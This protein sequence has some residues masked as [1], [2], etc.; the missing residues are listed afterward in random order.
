MAVVG[1]GLLSEMVVGRHQAVAGHNRTVTRS[2]QRS[3]ERRL[4]SEISRK[5]ISTFS[6]SAYLGPSIYRFPAPYA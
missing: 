1:R 5:S 4:E 2:Q 3:F 6:A